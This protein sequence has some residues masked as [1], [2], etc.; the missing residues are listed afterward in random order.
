MK[1]H[2]HPNIQTGDKRVLNILVAAAVSIPTVGARSRILVFAAS[3]VSAG[4]RAQLCGLYGK[5]GKG[6]YSSLS[7]PIIPCGIHFP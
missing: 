3:W 5:S 7:D 6:S 4:Y 1:S 2:V